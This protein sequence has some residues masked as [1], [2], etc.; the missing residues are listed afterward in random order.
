MKDSGFIG[1][2]A[3]FTENFLKQYAGEVRSLEI[4]NARVRTLPDGQ[5]R[6]ITGVSSIYHS[7]TNA[8]A[9][10]S[11]QAGE[12]GNSFYAITTGVTGLP[13]REHLGGGE[14]RHR[15]DLRHH[16]LTEYRLHPWANCNLP[17][18][19]SGKVTSV[20]IAK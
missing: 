14:R 16:F 8:G 3:L 4:A 18:P 6:D 19:G 17:L 9:Y 12:D 5:W 7:T 11:W 10:G 20:S 2:A 1:N 13:G 15:R